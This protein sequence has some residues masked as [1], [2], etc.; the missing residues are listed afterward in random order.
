MLN[1]VDAFL[2]RNTWP[3]SMRRKIFGGSTITY[4]HQ[5]VYGFAETSSVTNWHYMK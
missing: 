2:P 4:T 3:K 5:L 1:F